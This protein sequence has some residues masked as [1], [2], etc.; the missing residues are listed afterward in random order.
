MVAEIITHPW[1]AITHHKFVQFSVLL[2][3]MQPAAKFICFSVRKI[4][5]QGKV[6]AQG[7]ID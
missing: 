3:K 1:N 6:I 2:T 5:K 4:R 7:P